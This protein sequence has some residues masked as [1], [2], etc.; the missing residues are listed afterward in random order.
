[1]KVLPGLVAF[2][3]AAILLA[4][5]TA[6]RVLSA[7]DGPLDFA[8]EPLVQG[9]LRGLFGS[10]TFWSA[11]PA[12]P[13]FDNLL[14]VG[15]LLTVLVLAA[16]VV[17]AARRL[18]RVRPERWA[19]P[20]LAC[21]AVPY[22]VGAIALRDNTVPEHTGPWLAWMLLGPAY[23]AL[24]ALGLLARTAWAGRDRARRIGYPVAA[25]S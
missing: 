6:D 21:G 2:T 15:P 25:V 3:S 5:A 7:L 17:A 14:A 20:M 9:D 1:M 18:P 12:S 13:Q 24:L 23:A 4:V 10:R 11:F 22:A 19:A 8:L 16:A